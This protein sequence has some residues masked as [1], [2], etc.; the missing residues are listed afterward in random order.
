MKKKGLGEKK[1]KEKKLIALGLTAAMI[2]TMTGC[3]NAAAGS[4]AASS[5][6]AESKAATS[7]ASTSAVESTAAAT[8]ASDAALSMSWWG[9]DSRHEAT[10]K[11]LDAYKAKTGVEVSTNYG[12]WS[13]WEDSMATMFS[14]NTAPDVNQIN[15]NWIA[16]YDGNADKF[17]DL[18]TLSDTL[19][20]T[21]FDQ[22]YLDMCKSGDTLAAVP[23]S[24]TGRICYWNKTTFEKAGLETP[25]T[26]AD[27]EAAGK[28]FKDKLGDDYYPLAMGEYDRMIFM[29][30]YLE[31]V[32]GKN[33]VEDGKLQ[34]DAKQVQEGLEFIQKLEDEHV[35][36]SIATITGDGADSLDKD[37][38]W[39]NGQYAGIYE[40]DSSASKYQGSLAE[41]QEFVVGEEFADM[42]Q[43]HGGFTK[44]SMAF[45]ISSTCKDPK[46]AASLLQYLLNEDEGTTILATERGIPVSKAAY[47]NLEKQG[48]ID[49]TVEEANS[50]VMS[51]NSFTIDPTFEASSLKSSDGVYY[52]VFGG[53][54]YGDY[55]AATAAQTLIDGVNEAL[56]E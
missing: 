35:I 17:V 51:Y 5:A 34:Y 30:T 48:L 41:G 29:V 49:A 21:Q 43:Y 36:P 26:L 1:M 2:M 28:V 18:N 7:A 16:E 46:A 38:K 56:A 32:Y 4:T 37:D 54:S 20:L 19:D 6:P 27:L 22:K 55:D 12:A 52:D 39:I 50:K 33:W 9:G 15:W 31:S 14:T 23:I 13:G 45:A 11:A 40:W 44:V 10:L 47:A 8:T 42:G 25:K 53:L 3:G 24:M